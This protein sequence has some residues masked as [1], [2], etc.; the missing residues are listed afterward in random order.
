MANYSL[1]NTD[2][3]AIIR[4]WVRGLLG[5]KATLDE[6]V[7]FSSVTIG[8]LKLT[9]VDGHLKV[10]QLE[11]N[12]PGASVIPIREGEDSF[13]VLNG[14]QDPVTLPNLV[15]DKLMAVD[16]EDKTW[17]YTL[18]KSSATAKMYSNGTT[19]TGGAGTLTTT[20]YNVT[21]IIE[22][23]LRGPQTYIANPNVYTRIIAVPS[24]FLAEDPSFSFAVNLKDFNSGFNTEYMI[25]VRGMNIITDIE[26]YEKDNIHWIGGEPD[27]GN[28]EE[29]IAL[30]HIIN[31]I[32][33]VTAV[34]NTVNDAGTL[35]DVIEET[36]EE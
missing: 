25:E 17:Y 16:D 21:D 3:L 29:D 13:A 24:S 15:V 9:D 8:T 20:R 33:T 7:S 4:D 32:A 18:D 31:K 6:D 36:P 19:D 5:Y 10:E 1:L 14:Q 26:F 35:D 34:P 12:D 28:F 27:W 2:H 30:I 22:K 11:G 23:T